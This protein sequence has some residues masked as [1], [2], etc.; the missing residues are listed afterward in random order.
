LAAGGW[1]PAR[2]GLVLTMLA[3]AAAC[4]PGRA[5]SP[6]EEELSL[7]TD[8]LEA[9][10]GQLPLAAPLG[11]GRWVVVAAD[12]DAAAIADFNR[13]A[14]V[15]LGGARQQAYLHPFRVFVAGDTIYLADWGRRR[16]TVW[17]AEG[18]LLDS[19]PAVD[20]LRGALPSGKDA[21]GQLYFEVKPDPGRDGQG[22]ADSGAIAKVP[23]SL[24]RFD[25][26]ERLAPLDLKEMRREQH[27]RFE[28][29]ILSGNDLWGVWP[30]G[31]VWIA[32]LL[33]NQIVT[34]SPSARTTKGPEL[35]DPVYEVTQA[36]RD[37][38]L[39]GF[40]AD[41]R[42]KETD[43]P[44]AIIHPPFL[45]AFMASGETLWLE[46]SRQVRDSVRRIQVLSRTGELKRVLRLSG[47]ARLIAVGG[48][49]LLV[50]EQFAGGIRLMQIR[51]PAPQAVAP[52]P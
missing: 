50:A 14:I 24:E 2:P 13:K 49:S 8:T 44:W 31:T 45:S 30:D 42:P 22:N 33:R 36:D 28:R 17:S 12:W 16:T 1:F 35:P 5:V 15:P 18:T 19:I 11:G 7:P 47:E 38:Y 27:N 48:E 21:A 37:R 3:A 51:I 9:G 23:R 46:K 10:W 32:R 40:P 41:V 52:L 25:T 4:G 20:A 29:L 34:R 39:Q 26:V 43:F 6:P